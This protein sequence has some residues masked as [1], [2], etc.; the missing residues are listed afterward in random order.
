MFWEIDNGMN[1]DTIQTQ[2]EIENEY[3]Q[4][5]KIKWKEYN[6]RPEVKERKKIYN[7]SLKVKEYKK[8][9][10][11]RQE[12]KERKNKLNQEPKNKERNRNYNLFNNTLKRIIKDS[13]LEPIR[14]I[15]NG[16]EADTRPQE[17]LSIRLGMQAL[18]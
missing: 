10:W 18:V 5:Q 3:H 16:I 9:Y 2:E 1:I 12:V 17:E 8:E 14:N 7:S 11:K 4:A 15:S 6:D 13:Y